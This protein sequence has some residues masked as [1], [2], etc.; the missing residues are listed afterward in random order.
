MSNHLKRLNSP[1]GWRIPKKTNTF[2]KKTAP[3]PHNSHAMPVAVWLRDH[4][5]LA[6][7]VKEVKKILT[8]RSL[9]VNGSPCTDSKMGIGVFDIISIP[10]TGK[11]YRIL[12]NKKGD[13]V[14]VE[15]T[16]EASKSRL[17]K[18][19]DKTIVKGGKIQLNLRYGANVIVDTQEYNPKDSIVLSL[20]PETRFEVVG[21]FPFAVGSVAMIIGG[22]HSG[23]VGKIAEI[24]TVPGSIPN[25]IYLTEE[26]TGE[27]FDT[28][29]DYVFIVGKDESAVSVW[30]IEE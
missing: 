9:I 15:I 17:C 26:K 14:S 2:V 22:K 28:I 3:G 7:N 27:A 8:E 18:I 5:G 24:V 4:T 13:Y 12:R 23:K 19:A 29:E 30:G 1:S 20:E 16:E 21:H 11:H 10:K 25:R 6:N